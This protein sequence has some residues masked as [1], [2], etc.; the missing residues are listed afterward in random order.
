MIRTLRNLS[1]KVKLTW[2]GC[3]QHIFLNELKL[4]MILGGLQL[5]FGVPL[6]TN[7]QVAQLLAD[8]IAQ[9]K[10]GERPTNHF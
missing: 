10:L 9:H 6:L 5:T 8:S 1:A 4:I 3:L 2:S 7:I